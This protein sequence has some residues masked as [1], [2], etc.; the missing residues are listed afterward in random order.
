[1]ADIPQPSEKIVTSDA[2]RS[3]ISPGEVA[4]PYQMLGHALDKLGEGLEAV[5]VPLAERAGSEAVT[6]DAAGDIQVQH[7]PI[8]GQ[9]GV[10][11]ARAVKVGALAEAEGQARRDDIA[12][13]EQ[14]R[15]NPEGYQVAARALR[16]KWQNQMTAA[17]GPEVGVAVGRAVDSTTTLTY[18]GL[19]NEKERIDLA[20]AEGSMKARQDAAVDDAM[21]LGRAGVGSDDPA[22]KQAIG[23]YISIADERM[24]NPRLA[25]SKDQHD[26]DIQQFKSQIGGQVYV[27]ATEQTYKEKGIQFAEENAKEILTS[28]KYKD[29]S[30]A[31]REHYYHLAI[32]SIRA[33]EAIRH[34]DLRLVRDA[35]AELQLASHEG[36]DIPYER[37]D[38]LVK[39]AADAGDPGL[40]A[41]IQSA[42]IRLPMNRSYA[43]QPPGER[44][45]Q[46]TETYDRMSVPPKF[47]PLIQKAAN[48]SGIDPGT[49]SRMLYR[50]SK[51]DP[52]AISPKGARGVAQFMPETAAAYGINPDIPEE[53]IP[54]AGRFLRDNMTKFGGNT[55]LALA[56]YNWGPE[57]VQKW[58]EAGAD[59][60][61]MPAETRAYVHA[62]TGSPIETWMGGRGAVT[63][64]ADV[65]PAFSAWRLSNMQR[66]SD[67]AS[68]GEWQ[69]IMKDW[70]SKQ[71]VPSLKSINDIREAANATGNSMLLSQIDHDTQRMNIAQSFR[72]E[73]G[74]ERAAHIG[75]FEELAAR[76]D[77]EP[78][79]KDLLSDFIKI[80]AGIA[81][82]LSENP[83][84]TIAG[85][86]S[87]T[88]G[89]KMP[90]PLNLA[91]RDEFRAGLQMRGKL[92]DFGARA[93]QVGP[94]SALDKDDLAAVQGALETADV[95]T[96]ARI[97]SDITASLPEHV[98]NATLAKLGQQEKMMTT[99]AAAGLQKE[100]PDTAMS[101]L[102]GEQAV[103][104][105]PRNNPRADPNNKYIYDNAIDKY[106]PASLFPE[107]ARTD[108]KGRF[109]MMDGAVS[110]LVANKLS[111]PNS[112]RKVSEQMVKDAVD[113]VTGGILVSPGGTS[114]IAP[115]RGMSQ[116]QFDAVLSGIK[117]SDLQDASTLAGEPITARYLQTAGELESLT[118]GTYRIKI[119]NSYVFQGAH[120]L[121]ADALRPFVLDLRGRMPDPKY[122]PP[123]MHPDIT[124][125]YS[126]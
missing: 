35:F 76:G 45:R 98:R 37:G 68:W 94:L 43:M 40:A 85:L 107:A 84:R 99:V 93:Q 78:G 19:L 109:A 120:E 8:F 50:E 88:P 34:Q 16:E 118:E 27:H 3:N 67:K 96:K 97:L 15:D 33:D 114:V 70:D 112:Q 87:G 62:I 6:R 30:P 39:A 79:H 111:D 38:A 58:R 5:A 46:I 51:F 64:V 119:G 81:K 126:P 108:P 49:L 102:R 23:T 2:P 59:P 55:G 1:M 20:K 41:H 117:D 115:R 123:T 71:I 80:D 12:L 83:N 54:A 63:P 10:A 124:Q 116:G 122:R 18:R 7:M 86:Y 26:F 91:D 11:Y 66:E 9:A 14:F 110:A 92:V 89:V 22:M 56:A 4:Q 32:G 77:M 65:N 73:S 75:R 95:P 53:A 25:Y 52:S 113:E 101:I 47:Q 42:L 28:D 21:A 106:L 69:T 82:G 121:S 125:Q 48:E 72:G 29:L 74:P 104:L 13:R 36:M 105:D 60:A 103:K 61:R 17:A 57:N 100:A 31:M 44:A 24:R 90:P